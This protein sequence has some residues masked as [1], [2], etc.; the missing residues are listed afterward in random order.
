MSEP[1]GAD[2]DVVTVTVNAEVCIAGGQCEMLEPDI[3]QIDE[4]TAVAVIVGAPEI[5]R[6][7]AETLIDRCPSG[8]ISIITTE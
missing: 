5:A 7:R 2:A 4:D 6:D 8:A 3:F 1:S